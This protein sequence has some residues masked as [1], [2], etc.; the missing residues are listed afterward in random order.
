[1]QSLLTIRNFGPVK[2]ATLDLRDIN[3]FVGPQAS[4][5]STIAKLYTICKSPLAFLKKPAPVALILADDGDLHDNDAY[6]FK[7]VLEEYNIR[8]FLKLDSEVIFT[9]EIHDFSYKDDKVTYDRKIFKK[10]TAFGELIKDVE[11]NKDEIA[12]AIQVFYR[13][14]IQFG[15]FLNKI[16]NINIGTTAEEISSK[17]STNQI[18]ATDLSNL[19]TSLSEIELTLSSQ[20]AKYIPAERNFIPIIKNAA[21]SLQHEN[22]PLPKHI[23]ALGAEVEKATFELKEL[24]LGFI[25]PGTRYVFENGMDMIYFGKDQFIRLTE[26]ASGFQTLVPMLLPIMHKS[27]NDRMSHHSFV[28]E[29]PELN[30]FPRAQYELMKM[31][32]DNQIL[33]LNEYEDM[34]EIHTYTT[35]SPFV[36]AAFNNMLY[37]DKVMIK[38]IERYCA[39]MSFEKIGLTRGQEL[40]KQAAAEVRKVMTCSIMPD[41]F[42]AYQIA[43]GTATPILNRETGLIEDNYLD[44]VSNEMSDDFEAL[45][46]LMP[47]D[48]R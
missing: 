17:I 12:S 37:A 3:V 39:G 18:T 6:N 4:G 35:H 30:L 23:L 34:G 5:K 21:L 2:D 15:I 46:E 45:M 8:S 19:F 14:F 10:I 24:D 9:S 7:K 41:N 26:A 38:L 48:E 40:I 22:V 13:N 11:E 42:S 33:T 29:E 25:Q 47:K 16:L 28:I 32:T 43:D 20:Q 27:K 44:S 36:L 1:M 31:L